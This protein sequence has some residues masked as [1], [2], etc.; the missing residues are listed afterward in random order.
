M[1]TRTETRIEKQRAYWGAFA[2][3]QAL[4]YA[5]QFVANPRIVGEREDPAPKLRAGGYRNFLVEYEVAHEIP[6]AGF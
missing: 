4:A 6:V 5:S 2:A 3:D 1:R